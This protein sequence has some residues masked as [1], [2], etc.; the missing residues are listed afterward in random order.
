MKESAQIDDNFTAKLGVIVKNLMMYGDVYHYGESKSFIVAYGGIDV[1]GIAMNDLHVILNAFSVGFPVKAM[2]SLNDRLLIYGS[3]KILR[4]SIPTVNESTWLL[5][6]SYANCGI[7][8]PDSIVSI[9][10][11]DYFIST[12]LDV[13]RFDGVV[14]ES[15]GGGIY[16]SM[17]TYK[18]YLDVATAFYIPTM[19][20]Y[21]LRLKTSATPTYEYWG[22][23]VSGDYGWVEIEWADTIHGGVLLADGNLY[24]FSDDG[25]F[26]L[27]D[28]TT[29]NTAGI[30]CYY[31]S[32]PFY[33]DLGA[34][35]HY[36]HMNVVYK[37]S[38]N[39]SL[40][41][42]N[43]ESR[44]FTHTLAT[45]TT[46]GL[47]TKNLALGTNGKHMIATFTGSGLTAAEIHRLQ[48]DGFTSGGEI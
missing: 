11:H 7:L 5:E 38:G 42:T 43:D 12:D 32:I 45:K 2:T 33:Q 17:V 34:R 41:F 24:G 3:K 23:K 27:D 9:G 25:I 37:S 40:Q 30:D 10:A 46:V 26:K 28:G 20:L 39:L 21:I 1:N 8:S 14:A 36:T 35:H 19:D 22:Y 18:D 29:D 48:L 4:G 47:Y 44:T 6:D 16:D 13:K 15:I 31:K